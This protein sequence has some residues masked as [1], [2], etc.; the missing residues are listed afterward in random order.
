M[1]FGIPARG[2]KQIILDFATASMS[3]GEIQKRVARN[4]P[5]PDGVL[6][7]GRGNPTND[8]KTFRGPPRRVFLPFGGYKQ[9]G[10]GRELGTYGFEA[11][12]EVKNV[13]VAP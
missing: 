8:F 3:M 6:L 13:Y 4:Q 7:D 12:T 10:I 11:Y 9:S 5:I 1:A 2:G